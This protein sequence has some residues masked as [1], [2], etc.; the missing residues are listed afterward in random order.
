[1]RAIL[2]IFGFAI[3]RWILTADFWTAQRRNAY[4]SAPRFAE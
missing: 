2:V 1:M 4:K 3:N